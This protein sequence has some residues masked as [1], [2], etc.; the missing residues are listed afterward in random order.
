MMHKVDMCEG[1]PQAKKI[2]DPIG[3]SIADQLLGLEVSEELGSQKDLR[4]VACGFIQDDFK[5]Q[6]RLG[7]PSCYE[8]FLPGITQLL[9]N[10]HKGLTHKGKVPLRLKKVWATKL[11]LEE[12]QKELKTCISNED[13]ENAAAL[14]DQISQLKAEL[15]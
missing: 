12:L 13:F 4:C 6:G 7:C 8:A 15:S 5:K 10:M 11:R 9:K 14:R 2:D 3:F 1:C